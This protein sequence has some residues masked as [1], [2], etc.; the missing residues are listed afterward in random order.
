[1]NK[2]NDT[3]YDLHLNSSL[4]LARCLETMLLSVMIEVTTKSLANL[5]GRYNYD[6]LGN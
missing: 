3:V 1:M 4:N 2:E 6:T 5:T